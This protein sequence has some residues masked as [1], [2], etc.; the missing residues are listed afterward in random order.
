MVW[1]VRWLQGSQDNMS[2]RE[3]FCQAKVR[4]VSDLGREE[5][6]VR[7]FEYTNLMCLVQIFQKLSETKMVRHIVLDSWWV[8][9]F[10]FRTQCSYFAELTHDGN[11]Y[12]ARFSTIYFSVFFLFLQ[13]HV[14]QWSREIT[15]SMLI[16]ICRHV[17][18]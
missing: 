6:N 2:S 16:L 9:C 15:Y 17:L 12:Q 4:Q 7:Y 5:S 1:N 11:W 8:S 14:V 10:L 18:L 13:T 3:H